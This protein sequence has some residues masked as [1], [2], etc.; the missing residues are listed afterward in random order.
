M[1]FLYFPISTTFLSRVTS[2]PYLWIWTPNKLVTSAS[3]V[4]GCTLRLCSIIA[5]N[6]SER[7]SLERLVSRQVRTNLTSA[8][9]PLS[10]NLVHLDSRLKSQDICSQKKGCFRKFYNTVIARPVSH[11]YLYTRSSENRR[12]INNRDGICTPKRQSLS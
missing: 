7:C 2:C 12:I 11:L 10:F 8:V 9:L 5:F 4:L 6:I 1:F 3:Y